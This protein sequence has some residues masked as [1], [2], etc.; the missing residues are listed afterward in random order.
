MK[1][2]I[3]LIV[4]FFILNNSFSQGLLSHINLSNDFLETLDKGKPEEAQNFFADS[5]KSQ[6]SAQMLNNFWANI[7][8]QL[9]DFTS[10]DGAQNSLVG[11]YQAV[12]L[13]CIF[14]NG[15]QSFRFIFNQN[16]KL[17]GL[18]IMPKTNVAAYEEPKYADSTLHIQKLIDLKSNN[19]SLAAMLTTPKNVK[20]FPIVVFIH[21]SGPQDMDQTL[22]PNKPFKDLALGLAA[23]GIA[24]LRYVKRTLVYQNE[25]NNKAFTVNEE[26]I[27]D[28]LAAINFAQTVTHVNPKQVYVFGHSLGGML[29]P[30]VASLAKELKGIILAAAPARS[31]TALMI[32]Q[33]N[34]MFSN[35]KDTS[36]EAKN[37]LKANILAL[38]KTQ[39]KALG[40]LKPDSLI[41]GI[42]ASYWVNLNNYNQV[43]TAQK[44]KN[45]MFIVQG[46]NDFQVS[47]TDFN[48]WEKA[49]LNQKNVSFKLYPE[50][51]HLLSPQSEKGTPQQYQRQG[52]VANYFIND[53][54]AWIKEG[55]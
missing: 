49:L 40:N 55:L 1:K 23:K 43:A 30:K 35:A 8:T 7:K 32:E 27:D 10:V 17:V 11:T 31:L 41:L 37:V 53:L 25:F 45:R 51:N 46:E 20:N 33:N 48:I 42:P 13:N 24:S 18:N 29:A 16:Q 6:V 52:T 50:L 47:V 28:A 39:I 44:L 15:T 14:T 26:V 2:Y 19:H 4:S 3:L 21:G 5:L 9:G 38:Q 12:I 22:G 36:L 34:Y 54:V